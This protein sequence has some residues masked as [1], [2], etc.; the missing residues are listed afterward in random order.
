MPPVP[1]G[2]APPDATEA[3]RGGEEHTKQRRVRN[4]LRA[5]RARMASRRGLE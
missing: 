5:L 1:A 3:A 4:V 2:R